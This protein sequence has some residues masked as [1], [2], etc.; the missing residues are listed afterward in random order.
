M[1]ALRTESALLLGVALLAGC[2]E[3][4]TPTAPVVGSLTA[5]QTGGDHSSYT[6]N[7]S[8]SGDGESYANWY[9][10][11][12]GTITGTAGSA[13]CFPGGSTG[14]AD[15]RPSDADGFFTCVNY[16]AGGGACQGW[17][18]VPGSPFK[19]QL[20]GTRTWLVPECSQSCKQ[21]ATGTLRIDS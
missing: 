16:T 18:V 12:A 17:A 7:L 8:C 2:A 19:A 3:G 15:A 10:T 1:Y 9:W 4:K 11:H 13:W 14:G 20:K 6:W 21:S 5:A